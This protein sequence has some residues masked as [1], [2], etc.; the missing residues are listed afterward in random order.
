[1]VVPANSV[2]ENCVI[3]DGVVLEAGMKYTDEKI[4][5]FL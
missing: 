5:H 3:G 4:E 2:V 1:V